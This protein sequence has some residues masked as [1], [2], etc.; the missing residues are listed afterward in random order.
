MPSPLDPVALA[1]LRELFATRAEE[2]VAE[3]EA[4]CEGD[5]ERKLAALTEELNLLGQYQSAVEQARDDVVA[6]MRE[7]GYPMM[8]LAQIARVSDSYLSRR[9]IRRGSA[10]RVV[11]GT[12]TSLVVVS[13]LLLVALLPGLASAA[14]GVRPERASHLRPASTPASTPALA[15]SDAL[16]VT[17]RDAAGDPRA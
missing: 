1:H 13:M 3:I 2:R 4:A 14:E 16:P 7:A 6:D 9:M 10:R 11:R 12:G 5:P 17:R 15:Q 8:R